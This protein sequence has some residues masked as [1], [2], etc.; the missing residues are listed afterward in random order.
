METKKASKILATALSF[1]ALAVYGCGGG[2]GGGGGAQPVTYSSPDQAATSASSATAAME[3]TSAMGGTLSG[4]ADTTPASPRLSRRT[5]TSNV[6]K[7]DPRL[8]E[9]VDKMVKQLHAPA[10]KSAAKKARAMTASMAPVGPLSYPCD[11]GDITYSGTDT[12]TDTYS[13]HDLTFTFNSCRDNTMYTEM[14]GQIRMY[15]KSMYDGSSHTENL[16]ATAFTM[17]EYPDSTFTTPMFTYA[18]NATFSDNGTFN[19]NTFTESGTFSANGLFTLTDNSGTVMSISFNNLSDAYSV[20]YSD[21][22]KNT[23]TQEIDN[24]NGGFS[25]NVTSSGTPTFG[26]SISFTNL[27]DKWHFMNDTAGTEHEWINGRITIDWNPDVSG[28]IEG[29]FDFTTADA[30]PLTY[31]I[32]D[33]WSCPVSGTLQ[34]NNATIVYGSPITVTVGSTSI[35]YTSCD[36]MGGAMCSGGM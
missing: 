7:L 31:T 6:A 32:A 20:T 9:A 24:L 33:Y 28:C 22:T 35:T 2:G 34:I 14:T 13:E 30:T 12:S 4:I 15:E 16:T 3:L 17:K 29:I 5:G 8:K 18:F 26:L 36:Q 21:G 23:P 19:P 10:L 27:E 25:F 11:N 1:A